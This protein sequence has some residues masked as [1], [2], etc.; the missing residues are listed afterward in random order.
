MRDQR[1]NSRNRY[2]SLEA[3][4]VGERGNFNAVEEEWLFNHWAAWAETGPGS[5]PQHSHRRWSVL[6]NRDP[7]FLSTLCSGW[8]MGRRGHGGGWLVGVTQA[9]AELGRKVFSFLPVHLQ[10]WVAH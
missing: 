1:G 4:R 5:S 2:K 10:R 3:A 8:D 9:A 6:R 7:S